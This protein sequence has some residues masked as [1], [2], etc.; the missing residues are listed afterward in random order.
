MPFIKHILL[1]KLSSLRFHRLSVHCAPSIKSAPVLFHDL[2]TEFAE[3]PGVSTELVPLGLHQTVY[4][5]LHPGALVALTPLPFG[6]L[7]C[8]NKS[9]CTIFKRKQIFLDKLFF[10]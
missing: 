8:Y 1:I 10:H 3:G 6:E 5:S 7:A 2:F 9:T 4:P